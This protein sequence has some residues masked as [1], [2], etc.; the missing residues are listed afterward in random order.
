MNHEIVGPEQNVIMRRTALDISMP[1]Q[2]RIPQ[3]IALEKHVAQFWNPGDSNHDTPELSEREKLIR[4][5]QYAIWQARRQRAESKTGIVQM[6]E[7]AA[8]LAEGGKVPIIQHADS[9]RKDKRTIMTDADGNLYELRSVE[10]VKKPESS[11]WEL[12]DSQIGKR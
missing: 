5:K 1:G 2:L 10:H 12:G 4:A 7:R 8:I 11:A 6:E 9:W 3:E